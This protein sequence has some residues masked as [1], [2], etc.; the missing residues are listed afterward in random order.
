MK[1][2]VKEMSLSRNIPGPYGGKSGLG[3][4]DKNEDFVDET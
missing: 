2:G 1:G 4:V 3:N